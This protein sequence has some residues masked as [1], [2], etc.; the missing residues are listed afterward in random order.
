MPTAV[1]LIDTYYR[2]GWLSPGKFAAASGFL[3]DIAATS[4]SRGKP[5]SRVAALQRLASARERLT[6]EQLS[7]LMALSMDEAAP[8]SWAKMNGMLERKGLPLLR[9]ALER[10]VPVYVNDGTE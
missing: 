6:P 3:R 7:L 5:D 10:L 2:R 9:T 8:G 1:G 4:A